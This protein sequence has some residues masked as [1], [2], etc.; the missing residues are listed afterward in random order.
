MKICITSKGATLDSPVE[1][2]FGRAPYFIIIDTE[3]EKFEAVENQF[4]QGAGGVGPRAAQLIISRDAKALVSGQV[5]GNALAALAAAGIEMFAYRGTGTVQD[6]F[7]QFR[8]GALQR[9]G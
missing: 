4:A 3:T 6:A 2:R 9:A 7:N 8:N 1:E 5:G